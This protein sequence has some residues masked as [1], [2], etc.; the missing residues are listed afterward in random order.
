M[1]WARPFELFSKSE[2]A[3]EMMP[4]SPVNAELESVRDGVHMLSWALSRLPSPAEKVVATG[5]TTRGFQPSANFA[6]CVCRL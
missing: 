5:E 2:R 3:Y 1:A 6:F 4:L